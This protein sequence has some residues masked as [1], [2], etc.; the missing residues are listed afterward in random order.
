VLEADVARVAPVGQV[1]VVIG[2]QCADRV[3]EQGREVPRHRRHDQYPRLAPLAGQ[4]LDEAQQRAEGGLGDGLLPH[5]D[6]HGTVRAAD[7]DLVDAERQPAVGDSSVDHH[8]VHGTDAAD[9]V[10]LT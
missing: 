6:D 9:G 2:Q 4:V 3:G 10:E 1:H 5:A 7:G 8:L